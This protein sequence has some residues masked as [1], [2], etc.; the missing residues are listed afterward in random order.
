M[1]FNGHKEAVAIGHN[2]ALA[3]AIRRFR[4]EY[5]WS[6]D[7]VRSIGHELIDEIQRRIDR[8]VDSICEDLVRIE[9][10]GRPDEHVRDCI[11]AAFALVGAQVCESFEMSRRAGRN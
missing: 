7:S 8:Q 6:E 5:R 11:I 4:D 10:L 2:V 3:V 9:S 1:T